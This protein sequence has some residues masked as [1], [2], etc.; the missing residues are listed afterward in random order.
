MRLRD[1]AERDSKFIAHPAAECPRLRK[2]AVARIG[3]LAP[4]DQTRVYGHKPQR[5]LIAMA[6]RFGDHKDALVDV[7][8]SPT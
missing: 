1:P 5:L 3:M 4:T 2:A 6:A 7:S 8:G